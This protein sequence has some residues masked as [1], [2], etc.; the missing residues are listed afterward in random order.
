MPYWEEGTIGEMVYIIQG[1]KHTL[2]RHLNQLK[3]LHEMDSNN[4]QDEEEEPIEVIY[5]TFN[6]EPLQHTP[7]QQR[8]KRKRKCTEPLIHRSKTE[9]VL[10]ENKPFW[11]QKAWEGGVHRCDIYQLSSLLRSHSLRCSLELSLGSVLASCY[12]ER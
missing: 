8:L 3:K 6:L 12:Q 5:D 7:E 1:Q 11:K 9:E 10:M 4:T 2:K